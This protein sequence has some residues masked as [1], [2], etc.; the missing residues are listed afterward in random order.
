MLPRLTQLLPR[1]ADLLGVMRGGLQ[2]LQ[3]SQLHSTAQLQHSSPQAGGYL[4]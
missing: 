3:L 4:R 1:M 2:T